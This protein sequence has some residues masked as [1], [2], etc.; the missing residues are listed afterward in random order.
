MEIYKEKIKLYL[1]GDLA[2]T[3]FEET[4]QKGDFKFLVSDQLINIFQIRKILLGCFIF[5]PYVFGSLAEN[6]DFPVS[7]ANHD[8][9]FIVSQISMI[10]PAKF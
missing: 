6:I 10:T 9:E 4:I 3:G 7:L 5:I 8:Q 1:T 2:W